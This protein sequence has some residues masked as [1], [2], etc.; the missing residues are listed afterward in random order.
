MTQRRADDDQRVDG[1]RSLDEVDERCV[2]GV[3]QRLLLQEIVD[4][5]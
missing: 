4:R 5:I 2:N 3:K 1:L